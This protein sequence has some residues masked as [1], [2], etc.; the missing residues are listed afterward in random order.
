MKNSVNSVDFDT[1]RV[2][3]EIRE[4][5]AGV[6]GKAFVLHFTNIEEARQYAFTSF[7]IDCRFRRRFGIG[8]AMYYGENGVYAVKI[9]W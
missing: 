7:G 5:N 9:Y 1:S 8:S 2:S 6:L 3:L 4:E